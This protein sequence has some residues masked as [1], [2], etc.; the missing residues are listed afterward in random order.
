MYHAA[1][2]RAERRLADPDQAASSCGIS[3][4]S[5]DLTAGGRRRWRVLQA[6][7][8]WSTGPGSGSRGGRREGGGA[9][10]GAD[11]KRPGSLVRARRQHVTSPPGKETQENVEV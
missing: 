10:L 2:I 5:P 3:T 4:H 7:F 9:E 6:A 11:K 8:L 1:L